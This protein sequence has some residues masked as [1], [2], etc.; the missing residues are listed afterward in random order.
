MRVSVI[1]TVKNESGSVTQ[2]LESLCGQT[3]Q[4]D[5][6]VIVDGGSTDDTLQQL[7]AWE[8]RL[9][10]R[11]LVEPG[12]NISRGRNIAISTAHG[13]IIAS[14]D[15]GVRAEPSWL[16]SLLPPFS[17]EGGAEIPPVV[18]CGFFVPEATTAFESAMAATVLPVLADV[19]PE[20]FLPS[21][22]SVAFPKSAWKAVGGY[23][24]WLDYCEDLILD[25]RLRARGYR[26]VFVPKAVVHFRPRS[27]LGAFFKQYY[28][29]ARGDGKADLW[30]KRH[31]V[32]YLTYWAAL[33]IL[34]SLAITHGPLWIASLLLGAAA[35]FLAPYRRLLPTIRGLG[36]VE[37]LKALLWVPVIRI[38]GDIAKMLGYP[39]GL[40]W[41]WRHRQELPRWRD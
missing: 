24:E 12:C 4:P 8:R 33:P 7:Q 11:I 17:T 28:R 36:P 20:R 41:R 16:A 18:A 31:A 38:T 35:M 15:A 10:L 26:F 27:S 39:V 3:R 21:S 6:V 34:L 37:Q 29:Y 2:L 19:K 1:A 5:E 32:R 22:R 13:P 23:P 9:P 40:F 14:T 25:L 30:C